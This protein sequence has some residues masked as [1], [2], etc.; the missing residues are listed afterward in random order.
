[1]YFV[2]FSVVKKIRLFYIIYVFVVAVFCVSVLNAIQSFF[3]VQNGPVC[4]YH[5]VF[6]VAAFSVSVFS[7]H[8]ANMPIEKR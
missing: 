6:V 1:M 2:F 8:F 3:C 7:I 5:Y 4:L